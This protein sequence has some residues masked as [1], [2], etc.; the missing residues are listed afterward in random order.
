MRNSLC[1]DE[2][3]ILQ[4]V[5]LAQI[6]KKICGRFAQ[7]MSFAELANRDKLGRAEISSPP[8]IKLRGW[9]EVVPRIFP[10]EQR[11]TLIPLRVK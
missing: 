2:I 6:A 7:I 8:L 1:N 11:D 10:C 3:D 5:E 9:Q 4:R